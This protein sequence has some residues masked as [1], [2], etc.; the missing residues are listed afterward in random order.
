MLLWIIKLHITCGIVIMIACSI[1][2]SKYFECFCVWTEFYI[3]CFPAQFDLGLFEMRMDKFTLVWG[4]GS[5]FFLSFLHKYHA[6]KPSWNYHVSG[7]FCKINISCDFLNNDN[8]LQGRSL[9]IIIA[10]LETVR[11]HCAMFDRQERKLGSVTQYIANCGSDA[12][13]QQWRNT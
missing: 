2:L 9:R 4:S 10:W 6:M 13:R 3:P 5:L 11:A 12:N 7:F 1:W 8:Q